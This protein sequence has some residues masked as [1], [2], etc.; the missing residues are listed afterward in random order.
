MQHTKTNYF[1]LI[2]LLIFAV[3]A[4]SQTGGGK[5][6]E[7]LTIP[8]SARIAALG[9]NQVGLIDRDLNLFYHNPAMLTD[10]L[11]GQLVFNYVP[12]ISDISY[13]FVGFA[14]HFNN[15]GTFAIAV[16][17]INYGN[18]NGF[19]AYYVP[20]SNFKVAEY[21]VLLTYSKQLTPSIHGAVT[22][23]PIFS[24]FE[25]YN[26]TAL[27]TDVGF[28]YV[29]PSRLFSAGIVLKNFGSQ[30]KSFDGVN[31]KL[32][33][34]VQIGFAQKLEHAPFRF[35]F[36]FQ[37]LTDWSLD[38]TID[39]SQ[40]G[41][42]LSLKTDSKIG[43]GENLFRHTVFGVEFTPTKSFYVSM[44]YNHRIRQEFK[45]DNKPSTVGYSWGFGFKIYKYRFAY[46]S[47][48]Y[49]LAGTSNHFS[50]LLNTSDLGL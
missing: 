49:H 11:S 41:S 2:L 14:Q 26:S 10:S 13:G 12:Y 38:Y 8:N 32:P 23:K 5:S 42:A 47:A 36:T 22:I 17:N 35:L 33:T 16:H 27:A 19:D 1:A 9:G 34:D 31:E 24:N 43:F 28:S 37:G 48:R 25:N 46:A 50:I 15:L 29:A 20:T 4:N 21:A 44:G 7:F 3:S 45:Y 6:F 39:D 30:I 40:N 18:F